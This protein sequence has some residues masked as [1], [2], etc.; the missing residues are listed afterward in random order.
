MTIILNDEI[1]VKRQ[2]QR[3][4]N[5]DRVPKYRAVWVEL[6]PGD[7]DPTNRTHRAIVLDRDGTIYRVYMFDPL[8]LPLF[9]D[10]FFCHNIDNYST[11]EPW[12]PER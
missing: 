11:D 8:F 7:R 4:A 2:Q 9:D 10:V 5:L 12:T 3:K 6:E 1:L